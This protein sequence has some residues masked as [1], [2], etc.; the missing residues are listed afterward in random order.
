MAHG[1]N[2]MSRP[3]PDIGEWDDDTRAVRLGT[4]ATIALVA[5]FWLLPSVLP[6]L[7]VKTVYYELS[8]TWPAS[9]PLR[10]L[11]Y[12]GGA[13]GGFV[14]AYLTQGRWEDGLVNTLRAAVHA[15]GVLYVV[16][17]LSFLGTSLYY[18]GTLPVIQ[19]LLSPVILGFAVAITTVVGGA[20]ASVLDHE[21]RQVLSD[22]GQ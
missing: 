19:A 5:F 1:P 3:Y 6:V 15:L 4:L 22:R 7:E 20:V 2:V 9:N 8:G 21:A 12:V 14:T 11:R 18:Y 16:V 13:I 10:P 17:G